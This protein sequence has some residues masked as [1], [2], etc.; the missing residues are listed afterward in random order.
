MTLNP[1][2]LTSALVLFLFL[3]PAFAQ[4]SAEP[5]VKKVIAQFEEG[6]QKRDLGL[7]EGVV[8]PDIV[9][10]EN[11]HRN[12][13]WV[14]FR[15]NHLLP[16]MKDSANPAKSEL[17]RV[18]AS[19]DMGWGYTKTE[20]PITRKN[21]EKATLLLWSTYF[22]EKRERGWKIAFLDWSIRQLAPNEKRLG[23]GSASPGENSGWTVESLTKRLSEVGLR[24]RQDVTVEQPFLTVPGRVLVVGDGEAEIQSY[25]YK[26]EA[27]RARDTANLDPKRVAPPT[28]QVSWL[29]PASLVT[30]RN[31]A[32]IILTRDESLRAKI[33]GAITSEK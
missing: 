14:D 8:A 13:G 7:I 15:N 23:S 17:V 9:V 20:I 12:D 32:L 28:V 6:L 19:S 18:K 3:C 31:V 33:T 21:G 29:M 4:E 16:E 24:V 22:V 30:S 25:V 11:G 26:D 10:L 2:K 27:S 1:M 5:Q